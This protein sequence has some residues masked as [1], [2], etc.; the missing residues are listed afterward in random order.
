MQLRPYTDY[1]AQLSYVLNR[2]LTATLYFIYGHKATAFLPYESGND[3]I[4][5]CQTVNLDF[6][7]SYGLNVKV[8][9]SAGNW[10]KGIWQSRKSWKP[11]YWLMT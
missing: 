5:S 11:N 1:S 8:P 10:P 3:P 4:L 2:R 6:R 9:F 7:R